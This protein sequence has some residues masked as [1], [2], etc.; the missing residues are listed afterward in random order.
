MTLR[1]TSGNPRMPEA[2]ALLEASH[3]LMQSLFPPED[4]HFLTIETLCGPDIRF[5][6]ARCADR[7][8]GCGALALRNDYGELK[9]MFV[10]PEARGSGAGSALVVELESVA[11]AEGLS[12]LRLETGN[13]LD[14]A[15]RL[16]A[17]HGFACRGPFGTYRTNA[18]SVFMEKQLA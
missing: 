18:T 5:R 3:R 13:T 4:N 8:I 7:V 11:R 17:R 16:Y 9:S 14:A 10:A 1:I 2:A 15:H 12:V 6:I